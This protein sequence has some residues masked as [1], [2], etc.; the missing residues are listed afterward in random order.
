MTSGALLPIAKAENAGARMAKYE[1]LKLHLIRHHPRELTMTFDEIEKVLEARLPASARRPQFWANTIG[2][3]GH[4]QR[5][6][7]RSARYNAFLV[8]EED[9]VRFVP[10]SF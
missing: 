6:A 8:A 7:W 9:K 5:E 1:P 2:D 3:V 4:I 10:H